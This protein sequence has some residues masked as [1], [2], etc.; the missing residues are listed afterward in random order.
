M[1][2][3][4]ALVLVVGFS[5]SAS[6]QSGVV[7]R[8][9]ASGNLVRDNGPYSPRGVNQGPVNNGP[10]RTAP[11]QPSTAGAGHNRTIIRR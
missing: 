10:I 8:R 9:D 5:L 2:F 7:A 3:L 6:A 1:K 4:V 11:T